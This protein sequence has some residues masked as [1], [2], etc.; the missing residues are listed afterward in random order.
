MGVVLEPEA[1]IQHPTRETLLGTTPHA[2]VRQSHK[3][4]VFVAAHAA[5]VFASQIARERKRHLVEKLGWPVVILDFDA[6]IRVD[7]R[8]PSSRMDGTQSVFAH[9]I[10]VEHKRDPGLQTIDDLA[11]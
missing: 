9:A 6:V 8:A 5:T 4:F 10:V 2:T 11:A 3:R 1:V 7:T